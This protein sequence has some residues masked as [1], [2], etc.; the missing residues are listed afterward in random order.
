MLNENLKK[1]R[2]SKGLTQEEL[3]IKL[4]V[5]RQTVSKWEQGLSVPDSEMLIKLAEEFDTSVSALLGEEVITDNNIQL[6]AIATKL[7]LINE[8][9][10]KRNEQRRKIWRLAFIVTGILA[11]LALLKSLISSIYIA[12]TT[13]AMNSNPSIIGG[14]DGPTN[15]M[16]LDTSIINY[17]AIIIAVLIVIVAIVGICKTK[18]R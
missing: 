18:R 12:A 5:V 10:V 8:Q 14:A 15:I 4:N 11:L 7:E 16:V 3:A 6:K 1:L 2:K 13:N 17:P 9:L